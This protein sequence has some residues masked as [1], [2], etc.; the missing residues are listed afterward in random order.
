[1]KKLTD[2]QVKEAVESVYVLKAT[3]VQLQKNL[4][5]RN[6]KIAKLNK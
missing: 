4:A 5:I 2:Q 6:R 1:M 3:I